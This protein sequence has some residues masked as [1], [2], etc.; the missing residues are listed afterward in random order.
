M[1]TAKMKHA[2]LAIAAAIVAFSAFIWVDTKPYRTALADMPVTMPVSAIDAA[3]K[4]AEADI[5]RFLACTK[6]AGL[7][8]TPEGRGCLVDA[9]S[10]SQTMVGAIS[11]SVVSSSWLEKKPDDAEIRSLALNAIAKARSE[12]I[13]SKSW[14]YDSLEKLAKAHDQS[15]FLKLRDGRMNTS[16]QFINDAERLDRAEYSVLLP[17]VTRKQEQWL[18][19]QIKMVER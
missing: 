19:D 18:T 7:Q 5:S 13:A 17:D 12:M 3:K 1:A 9:M 14:H 16:N 10:Q 8:Y 15:I 11:F 4:N 6:S 2:G